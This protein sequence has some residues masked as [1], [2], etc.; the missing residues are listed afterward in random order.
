MIA[1]TGLTGTDPLY[2]PCGR[3]RAASGQRCR[4]ITGKRAGLHSDRMRSVRLWLRYGIGG[5]A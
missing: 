3:C 4:S 1:A 2:W 5:R